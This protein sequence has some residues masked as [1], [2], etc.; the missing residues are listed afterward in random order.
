[1]DLESATKLARSSQL[2]TASWPRPW[3]RMWLKLVRAG[4]ARQGRGAGSAVSSCLGRLRAAAR[5]CRLVVGRVALIISAGLGRSLSGITIYGP[6][7]HSVGFFIE[8]RGVWR[9]LQGLPSMRRSLGESQ[10]APQPR[11]GAQARFRCL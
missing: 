5:A 3:G 7:T 10:Q 9:S 1:M 2:P 6:K 8:Y 4:T 11:A